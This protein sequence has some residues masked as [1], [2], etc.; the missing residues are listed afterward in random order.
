MSVASKTYPVEVALSVASGK[1][2]CS[3]F[4]PIHEMVTDLAGW[5]VMTHHM[6]DPDLMDAVAEKVIR[7]VSWMPG[8]IENM[9]TFPRDEGAEA[10]VRAFTSRIAEAHG[11][12][13]TIELGEP[14]AELGLF[15]GLDRIGSDL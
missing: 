11:P 2:L 12:T 6:A 1:S 9:P 13:V 10:A 4:G 15:H 5:P 14:V 8:A 3:S 7:Q